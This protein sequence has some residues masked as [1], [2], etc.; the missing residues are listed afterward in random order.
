M[1]FIISMLGVI[2][3]ALVDGGRVLVWLSDQGECEDVLGL[4]QLDDFDMAVFLSRTSQQ[5]RPLF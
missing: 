2:Q 3:V 5:Y 1:H 4:L